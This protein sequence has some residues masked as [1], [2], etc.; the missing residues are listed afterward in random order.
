LT[1][2]RVLVYQTIFKYTFKSIRVG[3]WKNGLVSFS[4]RYFCLD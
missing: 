1:G 4:I 3:S 2:N